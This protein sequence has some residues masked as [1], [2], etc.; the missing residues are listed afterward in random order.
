M[1]QEASAPHA[2][3]VASATIVNCDNVAGLRALPSDSVALTVTSPPY[4]DRRTY[5][6]FS[7]Q[8]ESLFVE[9]FRVTKPGGIV[10]WNVQDE[11][12]NGVKTLTSFRQVF[13][14]SA[15]GF[16]LLDTMIYAKVKVLPLPLGAR[17]QQGFEFMFVFVKGKAATFNP[18]KEPCIYGGQRS[19]ARR[20]HKARNGETLMRP[21]RVTMHE[22]TRS[23][24]WHML[25]GEDATGHPAPFPLQLATDHVLSWS[26]PGDLVIDPFSGSG[27]TAKAC[28]LHGRNFVGFEL[29]REYCDLSE[30]RLRSIEP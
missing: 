2:F 11:T 12:K 6:G 9:L 23:N 22:K 5:S 28:I 3:T 25:S 18:I 30:R 27:T 10:V 29:S 7:V 13:A 16:G 8:W 19:P 21:E 15:V 1:I 4:D 24:V 26:N 14:F 20:S 17:Y